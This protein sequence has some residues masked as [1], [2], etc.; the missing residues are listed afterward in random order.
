MKLTKEIYKAAQVQ[1]SEQRVL[2][3]TTTEEL[4]GI[5][6]N[7]GDK[8]LL[9]KKGAVIDENNLIFQR[10]LSYNSG[11]IFMEKEGEEIFYSD[12]KQVKQVIEK[13]H[14]FNSLQI[15][16]NI[17]I[18]QVTNMDSAFNKEHYLFIDF[19]LHK[20]PCYPNL[21]LNDSIVHGFSNDINVY[22]IETGNLLWKEVTSS[23]FPLDDRNDNFSSNNYL[24]IPLL[25]GRLLCVELTTGKQHWLWE[26]GIQYVSYSLTVDFIYVN[27]G[28]GFYEVNKK[29]G[30]TSRNLLFKNTKGLEDFSC[31]GRIWSYD[32][33]IVVRRS[34]TGDMA[35]IDRETFQLVGRT[36]VDEAGIPESPL[37]I[38][39]VDGYLYV[40][41]T[42]S[43]VY[44]YEIEKYIENST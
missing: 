10:F 23:E 1:F 14:Y 25:G 27:Y 21:I 16:S 19:E 7:S 20:L 30:K 28:D 43:T 2:I 37:A 26:S 8:I 18:A 5:M 22:E 3:G 39:Y 24:Y 11:L 31:N 44:I 42:S 29:L 38:H 4:H 12:L 34:H 15:R 41:A 9:L 36:I 33:I 17:N 40:H 35:V 13:E 32:D 6:P